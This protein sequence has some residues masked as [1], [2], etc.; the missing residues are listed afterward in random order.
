MPLT[1][2]TSSLSLPTASEAA[3]CRNCGNIICEGQ[4]LGACLYCHAPPDSHG[5]PQMQSDDRCNL[6]RAKRHTVTEDEGAYEAAV[7]FRNTILGNVYGSEGS[8]GV[9]VI[10]DQTSF[11]DYEE[12]ERAREE[13]EETVSMAFLRETLF[14]THAAVEEPCSASC[15]YKKKDQKDKGPRRAGGGG[16]NVTTYTPNP[17]EADTKG[18]VAGKGS[19]RGGRGAPGGKRDNNPRPSTR[20]GE[21]GGK[22]GKGETG[23][24]ENGP[25]GQGDGKGKGRHRGR[26]RGKGKGKSKV[27]GGDK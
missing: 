19:G 17:E 16:F 25:R 6:K 21:K 27:G 11:I 18:Q 5:I 22:G 20:Q 1:Y 12:R 4:G 8:Q 3:M 15:T 7:S 26:G 24:R 9:G 13:A 23:E 10:D 2:P 14:Q